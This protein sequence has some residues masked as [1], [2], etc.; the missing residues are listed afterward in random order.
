MLLRATDIAKSFGGRELFREVSL[1]IAPGDRIGLLGANG[2]GKSTLA[3]ILS[4]EEPPDAGR[5]ST[6]RRVRVARLRQEVDPRRDRSVIEEVRTAFG[7]LDA[8]EQELRSIEAAMERHGRAGEAI[9]ES[10]S[11]RYDQAR[12]AFEF[13]GG[14]EREARA[15]AILEGLGFSAASRAKPLSSFSG[16]WLM[17]VE[18]ARLLLSAPDVLLL[19]EPTNH[20]DLPSIEWFESAMDGYQGGIVVISHDR[21][22][23]RRQANRIAELAGGRLAL[24][25]GGFDAWRSEQA[26][27][28]EQR[29]AR[30]KEQAREIAQTERFIER[31][32]SKATK[33]RQVQSRI[34][35]LDRIERVEAGAETPRRLRFRIPEPAR[36]GEVVLDL[37]DVAKRYGE[38]SVYAGVD[39]QI[40]RGERVALVGGNGAGKSTLLRIAAGTLAPDAGSR[41]LGHQVEVAFFAQHQIEVLDPARSVLEELS[42]IARSDDV[43]R[44][45]GHLGAFLFS[46]DD[47]EKRVAVL[48]GGEKSRLALARLLLRPSNFLVL[49]EPTNHLDLAACEVLEQALREYRGTLLMIS[50][51][52]DF[53]AAVATRVIEVRAGRLLE[54]AAERAQAS[55]SAAPQP[56]VLAQAEASGSEPPRAP[57]L[58]P[59]KRERMQA[60]ERAQQQAR[61]RSRS[62]R[63]A[64]DLEEEIGDLEVEVANAERRL[65]EP[66]VYRDGARVREVDAQLRALR[67]ALDG[68]YGEWEQLASEL[69]SEGDEEACD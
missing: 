12:H 29:E 37:R 35:A 19:D 33:A 34:R 20:L 6:P 49:D 16:G 64:R 7:E 10:V 21:A 17:R 59:G 8:L 40:R 28:A 3:R 38:R 9:P 14:F 46:G 4:G 32:R 22:L 1:E 11:S 69:E 52:R 45:R 15:E 57:G 36:A 60:R 31:F 24:F 26:L 61:E 27:R 42:R 41:R 54:S 18:L 30:A 2:S 53:I 51:D 66:D 63:R 5:V 58:R 50:H 44:L 43:P 55:F 39:L 13:G 62:L 67:T 68:R 65:A 48:S 23:L 56:G 25:R 47:V